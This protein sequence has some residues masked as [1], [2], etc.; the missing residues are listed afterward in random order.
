MADITHTRAANGSRDLITWAT[1]TGSNVA[2]N[3]YEPD[4]TRAVLSAVHFTGTFDSATAV[5]QGGNDGSN[6]VT[7]KDTSGTPISLTA[8]GYAEVS[9]AMAYIRPS[10]SGGGGSQDIDCILVARG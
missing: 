4:R 10:T 1:L 7:L 9:T 6:W 5:L 2:G 8:A 3:G